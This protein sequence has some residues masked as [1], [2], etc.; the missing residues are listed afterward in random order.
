MFELAFDSECGDKLAHLLD[1]DERVS[2]L[3]AVGVMLNDDFFCGSFG[4]YSG[5]GAEMMSEMMSGK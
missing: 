4:N 1:E 5:G 2:V 3:G